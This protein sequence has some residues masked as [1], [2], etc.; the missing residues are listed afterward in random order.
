MSSYK[1]GQVLDARTFEQTHYYK[2]QTENGLVW[3]DQFLD[4]HKPSDAPSRKN[5]N[6]AFSRPAMCAHFFDESER[7][8]AKLYE[9][10][11]TNPIGCPMAMIAVIM[12]HGYD[13]DVSLASEYWNPK[14]EWNIL[15][16]M[17]PVMKIVSQVPMPDKMDISLAHGAYDVD[18]S[19]GLRLFPS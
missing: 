8:K 10:E 3:I 14:A 17:S 16:Y 11:L 7:L 2:R 12:K 18:I 19:D 4:K 6:F 9:V 15:E 13:P 5:T 1:P